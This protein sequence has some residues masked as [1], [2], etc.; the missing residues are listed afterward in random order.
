MEWAVGGESRIEINLR[1]CTHRRDLPVTPM[2]CSLLIV[3]D[4][5]QVLRVLADLLGKEFEVIT[6]STAE[7]AKEVF[8]RRDVDL[9]LADQ[10]LPGMS[11]VQL[12]EWVRQKSPG[13]IRLLMTG[14]ARFEDAVE[15]INCGQVYRFVFKPWRADELQQ[16]LRNAARSFLLERSHEQLHE[17]LRRLNL[18][19]EERVRKRTQELEDTNHQLQ[20]KNWMLEK[21]ALTDPLT[22]LP[23]R[24][25]IE[26]LVRTELRR[27]ARYPS[28]LALGLI[29]VDNFKEVNS[30]Y[31]LPGG[32]QVLIGLARSFVSSLRTVDTIGRIGGEEFL[33]LAPETNLEG[34]ATLGER[35]RL[36]VETSEYHYKDAKIHVTVSI[37]F[38]VALAGAPAD[39]DTIKHAASAA[40]DEAKNKGRNRCVI[41][42]MCEPPPHLQVVS[43]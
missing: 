5:P 42:P 24:R 19:L 30:R 43:S 41:R 21:L 11:G 3:D 40:M 25:A 15:A 36:A 27:R 31:L 16:I 39:F 14:V 18:E 2:N 10:V 38:A 26:H 32:D 17:E 4:E 6:A 13:T 34:A 22:G 20:Q 12:L 23:N 29:D 35:I 37:G 33:L 9:I 7:S 1:A 28:P 8:C